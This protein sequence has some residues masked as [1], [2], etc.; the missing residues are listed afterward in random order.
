MIAIIGLL[1]AA[2]RLYPRRHAVRR[3]AT[4]ALV[5]IF[6][7]ALIGALLVKLRLVE[8][9]ASYGRIVVLPLT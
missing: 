6:V 3:A 9:D 7:E 5:M 8:H 2:F 4:L 1:A